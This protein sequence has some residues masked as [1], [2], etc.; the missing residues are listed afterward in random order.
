MISDTTPPIGVNEQ[1]TPIETVT[2]Q[3]SRLYDPM[4]LAAMAIALLAFL[5]LTDNGRG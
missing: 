4:W 3:A 1:G 2:V 5:A